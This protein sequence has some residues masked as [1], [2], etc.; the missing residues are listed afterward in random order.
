MPVP[1][2][3]AAPPTHCLGG[4]LLL[5]LAVWCLFSGPTAAAS[6]AL[7]HLRRKWLFDLVRRVREA[8]NFFFL[9]IFHRISQM[10]EIVF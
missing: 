7:A 6:L 8:L 10:T 3:S 5:L 2:T 4:R 9:E 1:Q